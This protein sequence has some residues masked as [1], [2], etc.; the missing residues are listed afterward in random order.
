MVWCC[1]L[2][3]LHI[4]VLYCP[5]HAGCSAYQSKGNMM[6]SRGLCA[7]RK[8][9]QHLAEFKMLGDHLIPILVILY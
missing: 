5:S 6:V 9:I 2:Q 1:S 3:E 8:C 4:L 7:D